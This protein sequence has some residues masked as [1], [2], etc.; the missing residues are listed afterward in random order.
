MAR[1]LVLRSTGVL[2]RTA[3][4]NNSSGWRRTNEMGIRIALG[5]DRPAILR[6]V[7]GSGMRL[8]ALGVIF[9]I[10]GAFGATRLIRSRLLGVEPADPLTFTVVALLLILVALVA[11]WIPARRATRVGSHRRAAV[12]I[13]RN[14]GARGA[15]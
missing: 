4:Q 14:P 9:G 10:A 1:E 5:A 13:G 2:V 6:L 11:C 15:V 12:R 7:L 3:H 8:V